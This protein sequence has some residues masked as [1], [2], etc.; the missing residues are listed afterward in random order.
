MVNPRI[1]LSLPEIFLTFI[2]L[3]AGLDVMDLFHGLHAHPIL[4]RFISSCG[5]TLR[6]LFARL[7]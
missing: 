5:D 2:F 6:A 4:H 1:I 7:L 3:G